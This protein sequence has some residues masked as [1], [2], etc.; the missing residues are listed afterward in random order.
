LRDAEDHWTA[1]WPEAAV[2]SRRR[3]RPLRPSPAPSRSHL[4]GYR[5]QRP[6]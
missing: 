5:L 3:T 4:R 2:L 6:A 1:R